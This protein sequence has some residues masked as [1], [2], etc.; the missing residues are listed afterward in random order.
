[1]NMISDVRIL[2]GKIYFSFVH[3]SEVEKTGVMEMHDFLK[4]EPTWGIAEYDIAGKTYRLLA[5][6]R[7]D[8]AES[9]LDGGGRNYANLIRVNPTTLAVGGISG[10][11]YDTSGAGWRKSTPKDL[12]SAKKA[13]AEVLELQ[14]GGSTWVVSPSSGRSVVFRRK[15]FNS[16]ELAP[17]ISIPVELDLGAGAGAATGKLEPAL[18]QRVAEVRH[19][20][21]HATPAGIAL[22]G[23]NFYAWCPLAEVQQAL[24]AAVQ[25]LEK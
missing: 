22:S 11:V 3:N 1:V 21:Y 17:N 20:E 9:P 19:F 4:G 25:R 14:A 2:T 12:G 10:W 18:V 6:S 13:G 5:S 23:R 7:R 15:T 8:P 24:E 16:K